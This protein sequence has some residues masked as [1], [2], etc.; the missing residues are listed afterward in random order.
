MEQKNTILLDFFIYEQKV[1]H[2]ITFWKSKGETLR[3]LRQAMSS[4]PHGDGAGPSNAFYAEHGH[5]SDGGPSVMVSPPQ[6]HE[7]AAAVGV[8]KKNAKSRDDRL[9]LAV[10]FRNYMSNKM[11]RYM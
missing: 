11:S 10:F 7:A 1:M 4:Q 2:K 5:L 8:E 9:V 6:I 3:I